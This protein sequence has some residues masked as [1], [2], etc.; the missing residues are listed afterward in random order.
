MILPDII[1]KDYK[2][3]IKDLGFVMINILCIFVTSMLYDYLNTT[4]TSV[5]LLIILGFVAIFVFLYFTYMTFK[6]LNNVVLKQE[7][8][9]NKDYT[10]L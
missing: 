10:K 3:I 6:L 4:Y 1:L 7:N 8:L 9:K 2:R 5:F